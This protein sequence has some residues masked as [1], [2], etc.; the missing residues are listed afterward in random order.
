[1]TSR[2]THQHR[3]RAKVLSKTPHAYVYINRIFK[4]SQ[5]TARWDIPRMSGWL[6]NWKPGKKMNN[7]QITRCRPASVPSR[8]AFAH[9]PPFLKDLKLP[10][11]AQPTPAPWAAL[12]PTGEPC[13]PGT[14][15]AR[16]TPTWRVTCLSPPPQTCHPTASWALTSPLPPHRTVTP[17]EAPLGHC[18]YVATSAGEQALPSG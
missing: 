1:M 13:E 18:R 17:H 4:T 10:T 5:A 2:E 6:N 12:S 7:W 15:G 14:R 8:G 3:Y 9:R 11:C 16:W